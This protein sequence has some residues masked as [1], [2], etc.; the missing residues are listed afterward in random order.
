MAI[1][2]QSIRKGLLA[3][4]LVLF[5]YRLFHLFFSPVLI[6]VAASQGIVDGSMLIY[7]LLFLSSLYF[8]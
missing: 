2:R 4:M 7:V 3:A 5:Q 8:G 1:K 6:V